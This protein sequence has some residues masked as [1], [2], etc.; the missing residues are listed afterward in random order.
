MKRTVCIFE[1]EGF[2]NFLPLVYLRP[3]YELRCGILTLREKI[4]SHLSNHNLILHTRNY[5]KEFVQEENPKVLV[6]RFDDINILFVNGRLMIGKDSAS[7]IKKLKENS[8]LFSDD[9]SVIAANLSGDNLKKLIKD[10][11]EFLPFHILGNRVESK[12]KLIKYPWQLINVN[13]SEIVNDYDLIVKKVQ[14]IELRK[15]PSVEFKNKKNIFIAKDSVVD[16]FV[17][18]DAS[19]G[20]VYIGKRARIMS[21][22]Y[23]QGPAYIGD[24]SIIKSGASIYRNTSIG[25]VCRIGGE[26]ESSIIHSYSNKQHEGFLGHSYLGSWI[27]IGADTNNSDLKN[28]YENISVLLNGKPVDTGSQFVGLI[29]G[30][31]SKT[32]INTMFNTGTIVGVSCNIFGSGF[33]QRYIPSFSWGGSDFLKSYDVNKSLNTAKIVLCRRNKNLTLNN[34]NL[35]RKVFELTTEERLRKLKS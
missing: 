5:L 1:D 3:V 19:E 8:I 20:P 4:E 18:L 23:I 25:E 30:D 6:N 33:P 17:F 16:P 15:Y 13:G 12:L 34:E 14:K 28:N 22:T 31:H 2:Q 29:M 7:Q 35:L 32:A 10:K 21:H 11:N 26:V 27:N 9:G 24:N